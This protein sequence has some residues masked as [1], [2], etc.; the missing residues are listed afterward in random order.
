MCMYWITMWNLFLKIG[1]SQEIWKILIGPEDI[2]SD[3]NL[4]ISGSAYC[5]LNLWFNSQVAIVKINKRKRHYHGVSRMEGRVF[6]PY[7]LM[8]ITG[9]VVGYRRQQKN[10]QQERI[11]NYKF[12]Q[13]RIYI[14]FPIGNRLSQQL[15]QWETITLSFVFLKLIFVQ[16]NLS[17]LSLSFP[18]NNILSPLHLYIIYTKANYFTSVRPKFV[19]FYKGNDN[20]AHHWV[21]LWLFITEYI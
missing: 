15:S 11:I 16:N 1:H 10:C 18:L 20:N 9:K 5:R 8:S 2:L 21:L 7:H 19:Y 12:Q 17:Q 6:R 13:E 4:Q 14:A 3:L